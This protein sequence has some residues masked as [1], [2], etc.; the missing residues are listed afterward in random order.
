MSPELEKK[1]H[2][3]HPT[4]R[5][6]RWG[7]GVGEGWFDILDELLTGLEKL[8]LP[9]LR[10]VQVKEKFGTLRFYV[11]GANG[12][13]YKL[14]DRAEHRSEITCEA[15]GKPGVMRNDGWLKVCCD[16]HVRK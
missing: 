2:E 3:R 13:A 9:D 7:I 16:E 8:N 15:C 1:L 5:P 14:I 6:P 11:N 12:E 10:V 4:I